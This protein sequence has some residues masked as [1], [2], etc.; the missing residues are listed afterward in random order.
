V[1][2]SVNIVFIKDPFFLASRLE[3][4]KRRLGTP[5]LA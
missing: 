1:T 2:L 5:G 3:G 4:E